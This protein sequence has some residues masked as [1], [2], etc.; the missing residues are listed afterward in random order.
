MLLDLAGN[1]TI[2]GR[3]RLHHFLINKG[4][5]SR[6]DHDEPFVPGAPPK[7]G[8]ANFYPADASKADL[9]KWMQSLPDAERARATG[10]FAVIRRGATGRSAWCRTASNI[11]AS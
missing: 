6:L 4:P 7:P 3:A 1:R 5:W 10:F 9:E 11:R 8:G 2:A